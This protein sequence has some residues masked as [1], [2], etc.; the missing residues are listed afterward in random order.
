[1]QISK[2]LLVVAAL[3]ITT[4]AVSDDCVV[5]HDEDMRLDT[6]YTWSF[7]LTLFEEDVHEDLDCTDCHTG[8]FD[9]I[10]HESGPSRPCSD[11]HDFEHIEDEVEAS[12][13]SFGCAHCHDP[14]APSDLLVDYD[15][16]DRVGRDNDICRSCHDDDERWMATA[17]S[18][19]PRAD[20]TAVH[21]WLPRSAKHKRIVLCV[22][23]HTPVDHPGIHQILPASAAQR[24]C[25]SCHHQNSPVAAKFLG[26]P[27]RETWITHDVLFGDAYVKGAMRH[28]L[29]DGILVG[30]ALL[31]LAGIVVHA[32]LRMLTGRR[33]LQ[34]PFAVREVFLYDRWVRS[35][36]WINALLFLILA[37]T[38]FRI[39]WG[40]REE[41]LLSF[42]TSFHV[43][44][45][46]GALLVVWFAWFV[47]MG[48]ITKNDR[49]YWKLPAR[50]ISDMFAQ[51]GYYLAGVFRGDEHPF[52]PTR[53]RRFNPLQQ[54][55]YLKVMYLIFPLLAVSG[56]LLL[57]PE[58]LPETIAGYSATWLVATLHY[59]CG[60][61]LAIFLIVHLY[62]ITFGD[63]PIYGLQSMIDGKHRSH[64]R[65]RERHTT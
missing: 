60:V 39:H 33:R 13:H 48:A 4:P 46:V 36:H 19:R 1:M 23:C 12:V 65:D 57:Y 28:R 9:D 64:Q 27:E 37:V 45:I 47:V 16:R 50:W 40:G 41:P 43:H 29:V 25:E 61:V 44:N 2:A 10:P 59:L 6:P 17:G 51:A 18:D 53:E 8:D 55:A 63:R 58:L 5:C 26:E 62:L 34:S 14:H 54:A 56:V 42:E 20:L 35:W 32:V 38:G 24:R 7:G 11:C 22:C 31:A 3:L 15:R 21:D 30:I 52:H 49:S